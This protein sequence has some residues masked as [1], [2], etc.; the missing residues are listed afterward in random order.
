M[1]EAEERYRE[2]SAPCP[3]GHGG[4]PTSITMAGFYG[5]ERLLRFDLDA[6][7]GEKFIA[8][9]IAAMPSNVGFFG[10]TRASP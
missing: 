2:R 5:I 3:L 7:K 10:K 4:R 6:E 8:Q 1:A 9:A